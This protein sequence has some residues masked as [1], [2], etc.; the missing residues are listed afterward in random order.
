MDS[1]GENI[2]AAVWQ[3]QGEALGM[4][5]ANAASVAGDASAFRHPQALRA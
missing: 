4:A 2:V 5:D 1:V 3:P